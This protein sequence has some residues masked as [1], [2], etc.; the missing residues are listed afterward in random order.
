MASKLESM[1]LSFQ[2]TR[3]DPYCQIWI[4]TRVV[5]FS[6]ALVTKIE[7]CIG[8]KLPNPKV[9]EIWTLFCIGRKEINNGKTALDPFQSYRSRNFVLKLFIIVF[10]YVKVMKTQV[11]TTS[12]KTTKSIIV[13][14]PAPVCLELVKHTCFI[15]R[16]IASVIKTLRRN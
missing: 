13:W 11:F 4:L 2:L 15:D 16:K 9:Y 1:L 7:K 12:G 10:T 8:T 14:Q 5:S 3:E 6:K